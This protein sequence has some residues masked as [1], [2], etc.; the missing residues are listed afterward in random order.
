MLEPGSFSGNRSSPSPDLGPLPKNLISFA[1]LNKL[2]ATA[3]KVPWN[4]T[5]ESLVAIDSNLFSAEINLWPV[6]F[7]IYS[8]ICYANPM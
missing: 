4:S 2:T 6:W 1:I 3:F 7:E 8:A 5:N